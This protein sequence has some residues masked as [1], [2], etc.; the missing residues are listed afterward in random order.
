MG[1]LGLQGPGDGVNLPVSPQ[2][3]WG[4]HLH[5]ALTLHGLTDST[6]LIP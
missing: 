4:S 2:G 1:L 3:S 5:K 6:Y